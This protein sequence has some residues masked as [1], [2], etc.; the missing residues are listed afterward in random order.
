[1][2]FG[3]CFIIKFKRVTLPGTKVGIFRRYFVINYENHITLT[4]SRRFPVLGQDEGYQFFLFFVVDEADF[5]LWYG[6]S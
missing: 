4:L 1:M 3:P 5:F 2:K 6:G